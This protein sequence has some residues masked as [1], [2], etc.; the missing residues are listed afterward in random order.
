[1]VT[2]K[3]CSK[4]WRYECG[5]CFTLVTKYWL[6][7]SLKFIYNFIKKIDLIWVKIFIYNFITNIDLIWAKK[8]IYKFFKNIDLIFQTALQKWMEAAARALHK[9][10][11]GTHCM[12]WKVCHKA[13]SAWQNL[14]HTHTH[15]L[16][17]YFPQGN[18]HISRALPYA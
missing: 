5:C 3:P 6:N 15:K 10:L 9:A 16:Q 14:T 7:L 13:D 8:N 12:F 11:A 2:K 18:C 17:S 1:M 4:R